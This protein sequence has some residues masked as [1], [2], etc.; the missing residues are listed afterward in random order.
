[1]RPAQYLLETTYRNA[2]QTAYMA[3]HWRSFEETKDDLPYLMYDAINDS[4][5]RPSHL[6]L[7]NTIRPVGDPF[8]R[9]HTPPLGH[10]CRCTLRALTAKAAMQRGGPTA[11]IPPEAQPDPGWGNDPRQW[12]H[13]L[14]DVQAKKAEAANPTIR[15]AVQSLVEPFTSVADYIKAGRAI[16]E[17]LPDGAADPMACH[18]ALLR[19]LESEVGI[20]K[21]CKVASL[22]TG[23]AL[24]RKASQRFPNSWTKA[25]DQFGPLYVQA[26][27]KARGF[28]ITIRQ[29]PPDGVSNYYVPDIGFLRWEKNIGHIMVRMNDIG[30][31]VH[32]YAHRLQSAL[33]GLDNLFQ[34]LHASRVSGDPVLSLKDIVPSS[35]YD[36][37]E[38]TRQ[39]KYTNPYQ[40]KEY[41]IGLRPGDTD[42]PY[43][44]A[45]EVMTMAFESVLGPFDGHWRSEDSIRAFRD[46]YR[47][48]REMFDFVVGVLRY[49]KP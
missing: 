21:P 41:V 23:A 34:Q 44:G 22:G 6:A 9:T 29:E 36:E 16:T 20:S 30:N 45:L 31:A 18:T 1:M 25:A 40:G 42:V 7:D 17:T 8:W 38:L 15:D 39:D 47:K 35:G 13:V 2:V 12:Q 33:P 5:V 19:L 48:D 4:R 32:E 37:G 49:W 43:G 14:R 26:R 46:M 10:R 28:H 27:K 3:G 24:V 11:N